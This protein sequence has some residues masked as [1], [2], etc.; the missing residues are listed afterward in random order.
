MPIR[1]W[2]L[3]GAL[4]YPTMEAR[5]GTPQ[6]TPVVPATGGAQAPAVTGRLRVY[7]DCADC[8][9]DYMRTEIDWVDFVRQPQDADVQ[10]MSTATDT[11]GGGNE[12][13]LR[14][15]GL[16]R[17]AGVSQVLRTVSLPGETEDIRRRGVLRI[18]TVGL[19]GF[20]A[21]E[22]LP[23]ELGVSVR[24]AP[25]GSVRATRDRWNAWVFAVS[26][27][28]QLDAEESS[29]EASLQFG[30]SAD[31]VTDA[32]KVSFG[33]STEQ[34]NEKF[35][36][37]EDEPLEVTRLERRLDG[38]VAKSLGQH[39]S[40]GV[41]GGFE[42]STFENIRRAVELAPAIEF[43]VFPYKEY[44]SRQLRL[45][46]EIGVVSARYNEITLYGKLSETRPRHAFSV[47][48][49]QR[50]PWGTLQAEVEW[51]QYLHDL[52]KYRLEVDGEIGVRIT[53]GLSVQFE[54]AGSRIRDQI[55]L[56]RRSATQE[57]V[58]LRLRELQSGYEVSVAFG[59]R[60]SFGSIFNNIVNPRFGT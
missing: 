48:L 55:S 58:L 39:W 22:G 14:F 40:F 26:T 57:E 2:L 44:A 7:L 33:V 46:Y 4:L 34:Q 32:W 23:T 60:Y 19:L 31:R 10:V 47:T 17:Y 3:M 53:R 27:D 15:V 8:F 59:I 1:V 20:M 12:V 38:F 9:Q 51:T 35:D 41:D 29:R 21:R 45:A 30:A 25:A 56:P 42:V 13:V 24:P 18:M 54:A 49:D 28:G 16:D 52:S 5:G 36:L 43:N 37:D 50:Q 11:G 6:V